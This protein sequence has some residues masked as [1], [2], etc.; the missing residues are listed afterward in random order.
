MIRETRYR[1]QCKR[2]N[3]KFPF[4]AYEGY[5]AQLYQASLDEM[6]THDDSI[7]SVVTKTEMIEVYYRPKKEEKSDELSPK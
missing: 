7:I 6:L 5:D 3:G 4:V 2:E 1:I